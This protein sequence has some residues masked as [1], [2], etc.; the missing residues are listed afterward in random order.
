MFVSFGQHAC[1]LIWESSTL[2]FVEQG[3]S[4]FQTFG[5]FFLFFFS[6]LSYF[7]FYYRFHGGNGVYCKTGAIGAIDSYKIIENIKLT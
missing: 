5:A 7:V 4:H 2:D 6:I 1:S 3:Y